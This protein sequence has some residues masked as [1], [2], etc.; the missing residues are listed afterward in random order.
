MPFTCKFCGGSFCYNHRLPE[1]HNCPGLLKLK[2]R[3]RE[4]GTFYPH[5]QGMMLKKERRSPLL[6]VLKALS[7]IKASYSLTILVMAIASFILQYFFGYIIYNSFFA[8]RIYDLFFNQLKLVLNLV[9]HIFLHKDGFHLLF[10]MMFLYFFGP[11]LERRIGGK[12]FLTVFFISGIAGGIGF[13]LWSLFMLYFF[14]VWSSAVGASG[15][16]LG[17][18]ACLAILA[19]DIRVYL[20]FMPV[21]MKLTQALVFFTFLDIIFIVMGDPIALSAHL[22]GAAAGLVMGWWIKKKGRY[23][24]VY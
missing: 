17:V 1:S 10:N 13:I 7:I 8:L 19:P 11:E 21:P 5:D 4:S 6:P 20:L 3:A 18:F 14:N 2:E 15:A 24:S 12:K 22:S 9:T 16:L 23:I